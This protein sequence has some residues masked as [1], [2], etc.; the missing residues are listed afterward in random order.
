[1]TTLTIQVD[2][3]LLARAGELAAA[4]KMTVSEML[5]RLL[6]VVAAPP[7][8]RSELPPLTRQALGMLPAMSDEEVS[9]TLDEERMRK[10]GNP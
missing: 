9:Q 4:R 7:L 3:D 6:R 10:Y 5:E 2:D 1:M 8:K